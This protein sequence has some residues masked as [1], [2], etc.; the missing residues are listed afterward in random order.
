[1][2]CPMSFNTPDQRDILP[3]ACDNNCAW[4]VDH[5]ESQGYCSITSIA[6]SLQELVYITIRDEKEVN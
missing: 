4:W 3:C 6:L 1:M 5:K 2:N